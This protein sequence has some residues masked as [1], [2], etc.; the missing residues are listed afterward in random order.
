MSIN[1]GDYTFEGPFTDINK[2]HNRSGVYVILC[3]RDNKHDLIDVGE[4]GGVRDRVMNHDRKDCWKRNCSGILK[5]S[6]FSAP[7]LKQAG[8]KEIEQAIRKQ[9]NPPCGDR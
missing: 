6:V 8:R 4:S 5:F 7:K 9:F 2:L 1:I 3:Y